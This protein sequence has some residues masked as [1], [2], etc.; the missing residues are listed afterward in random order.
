MIVVNNGDTSVLA[1]GEVKF[2]QCCFVLHNEF[3]LIKY[4]RLG[5]QLFILKKMEMYKRSKE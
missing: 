3:F 4:L 1:L 5:L 2:A